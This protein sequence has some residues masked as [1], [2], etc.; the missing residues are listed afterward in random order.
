MIVLKKRKKFSSRINKNL[1]IQRISD[2]NREYVIVDEIFSEIVRF[3]LKQIDFDENWY[4]DRYKDV[5]TAIK[6][7]IF[8]NAKDHF[9][10]HG[11]FEG[12]LPY[13]I[14]VDEKFYLLKYPDVMTAIRSG[15]CKNA[16]EHFYIY[17]AQEGRLPH[18][19]FT[20]FRIGRP[21]SK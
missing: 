10:E 19:G 13:R 17:G 2:G 21:D 16:S 15:V 18:A 8:L 20:L 1:A 11:Y 12:R 3:A 9:V 4:L 14:P 5:G 6:E 7:G